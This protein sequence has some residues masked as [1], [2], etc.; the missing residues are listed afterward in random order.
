MTITKLYAI[1]YEIA[2]ISRD[3]RILWRLFVVYDIA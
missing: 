2:M 1:A 3:R